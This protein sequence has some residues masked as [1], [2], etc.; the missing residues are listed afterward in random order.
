MPETTKVLAGKGG[1]GAL[2]DRVVR[3]RS[4]PPGLPRLEGGELVLISTRTLHLLDPDLTLSKVLESVLS[5]ASASAVEGTVARDEIAIAKLARKPLLGLPPDT[6]VRDLE[7]RVT[8]LILESRAEWYARRHSAMTALTGLAIEGQG[9]RVIARRMSDLSGCAVVIRG[10]RSTDQIVELPAGWEPSSLAEIISQLGGATG[11]QIALAGASRS[12]QDVMTWIAETAGSPPSPTAELFVIGR[13][14]RLDRDA[15]AILEAG[16]AAARIELSRLEA[17]ES[18]ARRLGHDLVSD[19]IRSSGG[20]SDVGVRAG[21]AG[22]DLTKSWTAISIGTVPSDVF[23]P[24][25]V[26]KMVA[27]LRTRLRGL[28]SLAALHDGGDMVTVFTSEAWPSGGRSPAFARIV[29]LVLDLLGSHRFGDLCACVS[30]PHS[31]PGAFHD[32][33]EEAADGLRLGRMLGLDGPIFTFSQ[34]GVHRLLLGLRNSDLL[35][36]FHNDYLGA[37]AAFNRGRGVE[38][39]ETLAEWL[40]GP[41]VTEVAER[42]NLHRN[43]LTYRLRRISAITGFDLD[44]PE[45]RFALRLALR[46]RQ[47]LAAKDPDGST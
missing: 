36:E 20:S 42:M 8:R 33:Y 2:I 23:S 38:L 13:P 7:Q 10:E 43:T 15:R 24:E 34:L 11:S 47:V 31:G 17:A 19:L 1:L 29:P 12:R 18:A 9:L 25:S 21:R 4:R 40:E 30:R 39:I 46:I 27:Y 26:A 22:L 6:D 45:V 44:E 32:G 41:S 28:G 14:D 5:H 3:L 16:S 37:L 35:A